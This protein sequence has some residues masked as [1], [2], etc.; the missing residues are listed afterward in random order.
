MVVVVTIKKLCKYT[1]FVF[2]F[3]VVLSFFCSF[4]SILNFF[5]YICLQF[6]AIYFPLFFVCY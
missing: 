1:N 4:F 3:K 2:S 5:L 6:V